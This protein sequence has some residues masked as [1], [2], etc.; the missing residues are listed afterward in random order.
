M[1][2]AIA[3]RASCRA[4]K[5]DPVSDE[6]VTELVHAALCAPSAN[7][8]RPYHVIV[9]RDAEKRAAFAKVHQWAGFCAQSPVV[10]VIC[11]DAE[12]ASHWWIEDCCAAIENVLI[13]ATAM[14]LGT[15][16]VGIRGNP[17]WGPEYDREGD[18][19]RICSTPDAIRVEGLISVGWPATDLHTQGPAPLE[20]VHTETW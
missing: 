6:A 18:V 5:P 9:V 14:G 8:A 16:W 4:Y 12:K 11:G 19:R 10:L 17:E 3:R 20:N 15:C 2:D 7:N 1:I 13:Q